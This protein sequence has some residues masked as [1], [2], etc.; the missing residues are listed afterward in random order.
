MKISIFIIALLIISYPALSGNDSN[1]IDSA[2]QQDSTAYYESI[3]IMAVVGFGIVTGSTWD[4]WD[5]KFNIGPLS[6]IGI[7]MPLDSD[8]IL[9]F[10]LLLHYWI[11]KISRQTTNTYYLHF[12]KMG[13]KYYSQMGLMPSLKVYATS[14]ENNVRPFINIGVVAY[15]PYPGSYHSI[16]LGIGFIY[17]YHKDWSICLDR[18]I[19]L[20]QPDLGGNTKDYVPNSL[21]LNIFYNITW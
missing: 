18:R 13:E 3:D 5:T 21:S 11:A 10:E 1:N 15:S 17:H 6:L 19:M 9:S 16:S 8:N 7:E 4:S 20:N 14:R 12:K 2:S